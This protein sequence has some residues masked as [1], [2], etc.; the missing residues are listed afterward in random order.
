MYAKVGRLV[1]KKVHQSSMPSESGQGRFVIGER[2]YS[3]Y[4]DFQLAD[5]LLFIT[6]KVETK[7]V[8]SLTG[9]KD[10]LLYGYM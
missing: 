6:E 8:W 9:F 10:V 7:S 4:S 2:I 5:C 3:T 1:I